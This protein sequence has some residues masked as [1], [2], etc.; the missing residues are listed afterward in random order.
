MSGT[1]LDIA[2]D[3]NWNERSALC[4]TVEMN[5]TSIHEDTGPILGLA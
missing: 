2:W 3:L 5:P 1:L 4:G